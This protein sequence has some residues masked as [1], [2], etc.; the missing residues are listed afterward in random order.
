MH[1]TSQTAHEGSWQGYFRALV[2]RFSDID[3][4][5]LWTLLPAP[6]R[7]A[8]LCIRLRSVSAARWMTAYDN[9]KPGHGK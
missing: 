4:V 8:W 7:F 2:A 9:F 5:Q 6:V 1:P 3:R